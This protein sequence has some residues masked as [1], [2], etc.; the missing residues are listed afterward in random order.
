MRY[1]SCH[2][3]RRVESLPFSQLLRARRIASKEEEIGI[4]MDNMTKGFRERGYPLNIIDAH[5]DKVMKLNRLETL[6]PK[7]TK[8]KLNRIPF[9][10]TYSDKSSDI[11]RIIQ[12]HWSVISRSFP[13]IE[14]FRVPPLMSYRRAENLMDRLVKTEM[15]THTGKTQT[16]IRPR[17]T[18]CYPCLGCVNCKM[19]LKGE[20]FE[21]SDTKRKYQLKHFLT[22]NS[23]W[24]IYVIICPCSLLYVGE[25]TCTLKTR[26]N[27]HRYSI[28]KKRQDLPVSKH[29]YEVGHNEW[30]MKVIAV[31]FVPQ[32]PRGG[33]RLMMLKKR[34]LQ[35]ILNAE[36]KVSR[37][38][39][40]R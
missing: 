17:K 20:F 31:D 6:N 28:R 21:H 30:D 23:E 13:H 1:D 39:L 19:I 26:L 40:R 4:T 7:M 29:F 36:F 8:K 37:D 24:V 18:G 2:P 22:C 25:T 32:P 5:R 33:D 35:W 14:D 9:V 12:K 34:E 16:F 10:S 3:R 38:M 11:S 27:G 15:K